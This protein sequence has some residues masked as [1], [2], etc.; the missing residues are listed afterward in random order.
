MTKRN[1]LN[2]LVNSL[3]KLGFMQVIN[4]TE[5]WNHYLEIYSLLERIRNIEGE[6]SVLKRNSARRS[7]NLDDFEDWLKNHG[8]AFDGV[9]IAEFGGYEFGLES[10]KDF[11]ENELFITIPDKLVF[12]FDKADESVK[13][14]AKIVSL[15]ASMPNIGLAFY[16]IIERLKANSFW[17]PYFD[18][19]PDRYSTVM[20][21]TP[22]E[23][24]E[25]K[26][27]SALAPAL[28][29]IKNIAR[30]YAIL[31]QIYHTITEEAQDDISRL[32]QEK[33]TYDLYCWAVSTVMTRQNLIPI[34]TSVETEKSDVPI[35][36]PALIPFWDM[37][38]HANG[39][40][41][42]SY[43]LELK[44]VES[45]SLAAYKKGEQIFIYYGNRSNTDLLVHNGFVFQNNQDESINI[46]LSL[47]TADKLFT[48]RSQLLEKLGIPV[49]GN[50]TVMPAP[51]F[52]SPKLLAFA[53]IFNMTKEQ[54]DKWDEKENVNDLLQLDC[55]LETESESK[56]WSFLYNRLNLLLRMFPTTIEE[57]QVLLQNSVKIGH[58]R[59]MLINFRIIEKTI[60]K[61][62]A[63]YAKDYIKSL[64]V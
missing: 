9:K 36:K 7:S 10:T 56:S 37:A 13:S 33:F 44:Q 40:I 21:F 41:T 3:L 14:A 2:G 1:E 47:S 48:E 5:Q 11:K 30:Q 18:V 29:Q 58:H 23:L 57:D 39:H 62:A 31:Y 49:S 34:V 24:Q 20:Y 38:N 28:N 17:K 53:R 59:S 63:E 26:G 32:M 42:T 22:T 25:L 43:N 51:I 12:A 16:L 35:T 6:I 45:Y 19:L 52:I 8:A 55:A 27:S 50:L 54:L 46:H 61:S 64:K 4:A 15:I 60:L